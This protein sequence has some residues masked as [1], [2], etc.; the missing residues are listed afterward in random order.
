MFLYPITIKQKG[1]SAN[2]GWQVEGNA[3]I[4]WILNTSYA[5]TNH[6]HQ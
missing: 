4:C 2:L 6:Q 3:A 1:Y 5:Q